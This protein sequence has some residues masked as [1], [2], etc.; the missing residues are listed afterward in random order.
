VAVHTSWYT[1]TARRT[2]PQQ[3]RYCRPSLGDMLAF[4]MFAS[5]CGTIGPDSGPGRSVEGWTPPRGT[6]RYHLTTCLTAHE[7]RL[8]VDL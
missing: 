6:L 5:S 7:A 3:E 1:M 8:P 4:N 2:G